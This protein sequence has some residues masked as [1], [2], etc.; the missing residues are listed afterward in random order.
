VRA[1]SATRIA[2]EAEGL[3]LR[4]Q[5]RRIAVRATLGI[6]VA[7]FLVSALAFAHVATWYWVRLRF[8]WELDS[9]AALLAGGDIVI[10][11]CFAILASRLTPSYAEAEAL[12]VRQQAWRAVAGSMAWPMV[13]LRLLR[14]VRRRR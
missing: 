1:L 5:A 4:L 13:A 10:A 14:L 11:G 6:V 2:I 12:V 3:R 7:M 9:T 8:Q